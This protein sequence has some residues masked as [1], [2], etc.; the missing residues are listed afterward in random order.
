MRKTTGTTILL[1]GLFLLAACSSPQNATAIPTPD[2]NPMRTEVAATVL[3]Q[4]PAICAL[5]PSATQ[6]VPPTQTATIAPTETAT[7]QVTETGTPQTGTPDT[8]DLAMWVSQTVQDDTVFAPSQEF[9]MT[10]QIKNVGTSTWTNDYRLR[11][12]SGD[13]F[14]TVKEIALGKEVK[15]NET[16][17]IGITMKAPS[18]PGDYRSDWVLSNEILRNFK[19]PVFLKIKVAAPTATV[20]PT[21]TQLPPT[22]TNTPNP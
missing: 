6:E 13:P 21:R 2:L 17:E 3:A 20:T 18:K 5:T 8:R 4:V 15:P 10:W 11:F 22:A 14:G 9:N 12:Y 7:A 16:V 1:F 19:E